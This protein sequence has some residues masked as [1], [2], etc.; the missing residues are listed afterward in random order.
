MLYSE[1]VEVKK[2]TGSMDGVAKSTVNT[3]APINVGARTHART[4]THKRA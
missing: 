2:D 3:D 4:C 1:K